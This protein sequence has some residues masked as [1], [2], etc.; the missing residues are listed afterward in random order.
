MISGIKGF[1][2][3]QKRVLAGCFIVYFCTYVGRLNMSPTLPQIQATFEGLD[4]AR[5]G[6][7][8]TVFALTYAAG[9]LGFGYLADRFR[10]R[11]MI[12]T[13]LLGSALSNLLFSLM[14][15]FELLVAMW[16][17]NGAFQSMIWTPIV[18]CMTGTFDDRERKTA[19]FVMSFTLAAGHLVAWALSLWL[20]K[21][22]SWRWSYRVPFAV[23]CLAVVCAFAMLPS[24]FLGKKPAKD[25][26]KTGGKTS[27]PFG[28]LA[29]TGLILL[30]A[31]CVLNG[32]VR[33]G[34]NTWAPT[35]LGQSS[36]SLLPKLAI[37]CINM[38]GILLGGYLIRRLTL[39]ARML[40]GQMMVAVA[41]AALGAF[42]LKLSPAWPLCLPLAVMSALLQG[43]NPLL[44]SLVPMQY[45]YSGRV[46]LVA[47]LVDSA[48]YVGSA[49]SAPLAGFVRDRLDWG[50]VY[51]MWLIAALACFGL[52]ALSSR[53]MKAWA[54]SRQTGKNTDD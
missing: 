21:L 42:L 43:T 31:G 19:S 4:S 54:D 45:D 2:A 5:A 23:L 16:T 24:G 44:T 48:L 39:D 14:P 15:S 33:D 38:L 34:V 36:D 49:V 12:I 41:L 6:L 10:P 53:Q 25:G 40:S 26:E 35:I 13:G 3:H 18:L 29:G 37:P 7:L 47:G 20:S 11:R 1:N 46:G 32:F 22:L 8:Q 17:L 28:A 27:L 30:L 9:Q 52:A 51:I 50:G